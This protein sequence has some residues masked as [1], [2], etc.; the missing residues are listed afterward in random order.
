MHPDHDPHHEPFQYA[1]TTSTPHQARPSSVAMIGQTDRANRQYDLKDVWQ[2][3]AAGHLP[4]VS[5]L[6]APGYQTGHPGSA[7]PRDEQGDVLTALPGPQSRIGAQRHALCRRSPR[8]ALAR[9]GKAKREGRAKEE[10]S[11][12]CDKSHDRTAAARQAG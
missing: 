2:A 6:K 10:A 3:A 9:E 4:A 8:C 11:D 12:M 5:F 7:D 1:A